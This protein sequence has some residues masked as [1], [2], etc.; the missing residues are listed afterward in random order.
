[1][2][3]S[4]LENVEVDYCLP[5]SGIAARLV[6][7]ANESVEIEGLW[8]LP[9]DTPTSCVVSVRRLHKLSGLPRCAGRGYPDF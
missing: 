6:Q 2:P 9:W 1:M 5:L 7:L 3:R 4:A 8:E